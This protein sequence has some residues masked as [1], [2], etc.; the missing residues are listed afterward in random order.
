MS[1]PLYDSE[2]GTNSSEMKKK[3]EAKVWLHRKMPRIIW[4]DYVINNEVL[5]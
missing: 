5:K 3:L 2:C 4:R 1:V